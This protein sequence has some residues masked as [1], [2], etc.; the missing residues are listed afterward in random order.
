MKYSQKS[1]FENV[2]KKKYSNA[3]IF[4][5]VFAWFYSL[6]LKCI[7]YCVFAWAVL[8]KVFAKK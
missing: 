2:F 8:R 7:Q 5:K 3:R 1:Y 4:E 6:F